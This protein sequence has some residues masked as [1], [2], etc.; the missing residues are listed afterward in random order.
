[1]GVTTMKFEFE[2]FKDYAQNKE[3]SAEMEMP[4]ID[5]VW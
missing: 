2:N 5:A 3:T 1:M 4:A